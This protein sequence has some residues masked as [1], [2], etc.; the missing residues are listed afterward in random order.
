[1]GSRKP[2]EGATERLYTDLAS[3]WPVMSAPSHYDEEA[4][5]FREAIEEVSTIPVTDV[6]EL[7][8]GGG[9]NASH[10]KA[11]WRMTLVDLS[12]G[13]LDVSR[14][15]NPECEHVLGDMRSLKL[16]RTFDAVFIHD[17][18]VYMRT[19]ED[20]LKAM[21]T[22]FA[23]TKPGGV[24]LFVPDYTTETFAPF[25]SNGG[26]DRGDR[27]MR[28]LEWAYDPEPGDSS[29]TMAFAY[30]LREEGRPLRTEFEEHRMGLFPRKVWLAQIRKAGFQP[31]TLPY[32]HSSFEQ[33]LNS[34]LFLG[35]RAG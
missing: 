15:L 7:G 26:H 29:Y 33:D 12:P 2:E 22:A 17:A 14:D 3:W 18:I 10:L 28:Y 6:L 5:I 16:G 13:M 24:A 30:M 23:H 11:H 8:C 27:S 32:D 19:K 34:E 4:T 21:K 9:N 25:T 1:V 20:L 35:V 31:T